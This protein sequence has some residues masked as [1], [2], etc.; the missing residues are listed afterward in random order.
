[1]KDKKLKKTASNKET[2]LVKTLN[3][4]LKIQVL[5]FLILI[6]FFNL[7]VICVAQGNVTITNIWY[8]KVPNFTRVTIKANNP[9]GDYESMYISDPERIVIDIPQADYNIQEL[10][11]NTLFLNMGSVKQVRC[12]QFEEDKVRFVID[13]F[14]KVD[15]DLA[16]DTTGQ[17]LQINIYD[18][19][20]FLA[21]EK[22][23]Y[24]VEPISA[25]EIQKIQQ[26]REAQVPSIVDQVDVP[27]T[28]NLK[29]AEVVDAIR[30]LSMLSGVNIVADDSVTG[31]ITL[32]IKDATFKEALDWIT[33]LKRLSYTQVGNALVFGTP[34]II[35]TYRTRITRI[36]HLE[37]ANV[38]N[39][40]G[41][42]DSYF[43]EEGKIKITTDARLNNMIIEGTPETVAKAE[44]LIEETD[45]SLITKTFKIDNATFTEEVEA[46]KS[47]LGIIIPDESRI[48]IDNRQNEIIVK[49]S[50]EEIENA[51]AM[52]EGL[53]R[54]A[55]QIMIEA[56][57][58]EIT[59]D[60]EK[61]LG[62]RWF[63][64]GMD[65]GNEG[66]MTLGELTLGGSFERQGL[67]NARL[68]ALE[69]ENKVNILSNP[70][71]LTLDGKPSV[72]DSGKQIP[73]QEEIVD[74]EGNIRQTVT[75]KDVGVKLEITPRLSSD[76]YIN[77]DLFTEVK[78]LG[79]EFI[80]G[81]PVIN[82]RSETAII[83]SKLG[84][85]HVIGGLISTEEKENI[86]KIPILSEIPIFGEIFKFRNKTSNRTEVI[87]LITANMI[88][89]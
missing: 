61:D 20:E 81:Y 55:A 13:L 72:I 21:P 84:E 83:R 51:R 10:V 73:I 53:D 68:K 15:Y 40:K 34:E 29:E 7:T 24:T 35:D 65:D 52:I 54:R 8:K 17:L 49:G 38:E 19:D 43:G 11:K 50:Q 41:V 18:Y 88:E 42:L 46:I 27:I 70:K 33:R 67:I 14:Q 75:W 80:V 56:K 5:I 22:Q 87:M 12:G 31:N 4:L 86:R 59:L 60:G 23:V 74:D 39:L 63:S 71:I 78:S 28:L 3:G 76:G 47:M 89:Y 16:L 66:S 26:G 6:I 48:I 69:T 82:N 45:T 30:T 85:T 64:G 77:M 36:V 62:I 44:E 1:M 58:V 25:E 79:E 32:N 9:I 57:I 2:E 37:N